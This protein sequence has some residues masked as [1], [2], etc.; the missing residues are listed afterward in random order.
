MKDEILGLKKE[1]KAVILAHYYQDGAIQDVADFVGD[2]LAL[3]RTA[4]DTDADIIVFCGVRFMAETAKILSPEKKVLLP[5]MDAGCPLADTATAQDVVKMRDSLGS[6]AVV[7]YVNTNADVKA[8]SDI[9]CTSANAVNVVK[10]IDSD[11]VLFVPDRNLGA[12]VKSIV[13]N[14][15][16]F[17]WDGYCPVHESFGVE[18]IEILRKNHPGARLAV[19]PESPMRVIELADF[20]GSTSGIIQYCENEDADEF[21]IATEEGILHELRKRAKGK[22]FYLASPAAVCRDM[23]KVTMESLLDVLK[24]ESNEILLPSETIEKARLPI[25]RMLQIKR[26]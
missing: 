23:K 13:K 26:G 22:R 16:I 15:D 5:V 2:S 10:S 20:V 8:V 7:S 24:N 4:A 1:K 19:H 3:A 17:L 25:T 21:I 9:C 12:Y 14:K 11:R 6:V 18:E